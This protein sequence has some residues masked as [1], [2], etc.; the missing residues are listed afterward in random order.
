[1]PG[2]I[3]RNAHRQST[4]I[5]YCGMMSALS[6]VFLLAGTVIPIATYAAPLFCSLLLL[7]IRMEFGSKYA[8][9]AFAVVSILAIWLGGD[10]ET[11]FFYLFIGWYP[12]TKWQLDRIQSKPLRVLV[13]LTLINIAIIA[14]YLLLCFL[15]HMDALL[16]E[17][18]GMGVWMMVCF[19]LLLDVCM[20]IYDRM[21]FPLLMLYDQKLRPLLKMR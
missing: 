7:P 4:V 8:W 10:K 6:V 18:R 20:M 9:T 16:A 2:E 14:M 13:K 17:M 15:L 11:A 1:M 19:L 21:M 3:H 5:A 12:L